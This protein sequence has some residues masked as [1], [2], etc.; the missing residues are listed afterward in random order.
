MLCYILTA[1]SKFFHANSQHYYPRTAHDALQAA[2]TQDVSG[3]RL[4]NH[5]VAQK[6]MAL[7]TRTVT[8]SLVA[9]VSKHVQAKKY[10]ILS[11]EK[12]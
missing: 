10:T 1:K 6:Q 5:E 9:C 11:I 4:G 8:H 2:V 7:R 3:L 12:M